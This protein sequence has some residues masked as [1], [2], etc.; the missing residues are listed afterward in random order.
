MIRDARFDVHILTKPVAESP[1]C[2]TEKVNWIAKHIPVLLKK[3]TMTQDKTMLKGDIL[4]D[5][6]DQWSDF[7]GEFILFDIDNDSRLEWQRIT[8]QLL[9]GALK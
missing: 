1:I 5:D 6:S 4:I 7:D 9:L 2:Y 3:I 8:D